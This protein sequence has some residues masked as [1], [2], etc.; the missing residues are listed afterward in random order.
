MI[1]IFASPKDLP[2]P[3]FRDSYESYM[4]EVKKHTQDLTD[5]LKA[6]GYTGKNT[7]KIASFPVADGFAQYMAVESNK[8]FG[9]IHLEYGDAYMFPYINRLT[10]K[11]ILQNIARTEAIKNLFNEKDKTNPEPNI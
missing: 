4:E 7:G 11:D 9:L 6:M 2:F 10:K 5:R 1:K 8:I 3:S